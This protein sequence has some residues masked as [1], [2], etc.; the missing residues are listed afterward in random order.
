MFYTGLRAHAAINAGDWAAFTGQ[1]LAGRSTTD[2]T[3]R[4][5]VGWYVGVKLGSFPAVVAASA[6]PLVVW[7]LSLGRE[8]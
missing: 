2:P 3:R 1:V 6:T 5:D 8:G 7:V 4:T